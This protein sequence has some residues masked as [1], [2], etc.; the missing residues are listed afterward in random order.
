MEGISKGRER[1]KE[2]GE[3]KLAKTSS[4]N[5]GRRETLR[6]NEP[7]K[8]EGTYYPPLGAC[9][10]WNHSAGGRGLA[11]LTYQ[12]ISRSMDEAAVK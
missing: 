6:T 9:N 4:S 12:Q 8:G 11:S 3:E 5:E 1:G 2:D 10:F 7:T